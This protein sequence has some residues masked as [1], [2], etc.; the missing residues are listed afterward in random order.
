MNKAV[1]IGSGIGGLTSAILL[2][3]RGWKVTVLEQHYRPGGCLHRFFRQGLGFDTGFH[4]VGSAGPDESFGR[5]MRHLGVYD[6]VQWRPMDAAG[7]D[8]LRFPEFE[9]SV[10]RGL[11]A[12]QQRLEE[13]FPSEVKGI[14]AYVQL[15]REA[16]SAYGLYNLDLGISSLDVIRWEEMPLTTVLSEL[17]SDERL[18]AVIAGHGAPLYG[19]PPSEAPFGVHAVVTDHF[20]GGGWRIAGGGDRLAK[21]LC[22]RLRELGG[23]ILLRAEVDRIQVADGVATGVI[24]KDGREFSASLVVA[25]NHPK[26]VAEMLPAGSLRPIYRERLAEMSPGRSHFGV[27]FRIRGDL[28]VCEG[29]NLFRYSTWDVEAAER[30]GDL[31]EVPF[32]FLT[33]PDPGIA[34]AIVASNWEQWSSH[35]VEV[36]SLRSGEGPAREEGYRRQKEVMI[37]AIVDT[38][39]REHPT[40]EWELLD[41]STPVTAA[42][43]LRTP[44]GA[45]Y[46]HYHTVGQMGRYR[47]PSAVRVRQLVQVGQSVAFPGICGAAMSAYSGLG[48]VLG[49]ETLVQELRAL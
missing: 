33:A 19:V 31:G 7:F 14:R 15:H 45:S 13:A 40:V 26:R 36:P 9:I 1:V 16:V 3:Q 10:P 2:A 38:L 21:A 42:H 43:Y 30:G 47:I 39:R 20:L 27:Y 41:A 34:L 6:R 48:G 32:Y 37:R 46:G 24:L 17:F 28:A 44:N 12:W 8:V 11:T 29:R 22:S 25:N 4:Y 5:I 23:E 49:L 35:H 18:R